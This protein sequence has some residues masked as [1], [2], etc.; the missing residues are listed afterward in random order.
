[1]I[2]ALVFSCDRAMQLDGLL[3]SI[4][5]HRV[6]YRSLTVLAHNWRHTDALAVVEAEHPD[7][8][9]VAVDGA[10]PFENEVRW[11][12]ATHDRVVFHVDDA[13]FFARPDPVVLSVESAAVSMQLGRNTV[14]CRTELGG[15]VRQKV[16]PGLVW[17][18]RDAD[19]DFGYPLSINATVY[20]TEDLLPLMDFDFGNPNQLE[21]RLHDRRERFGPE[22]MVCSPHSSCVSL[23]HNAVSPASLSP[24]GDN[25][26]WQPEALRE[27][28]MA[29]ER[30]DLG[31]MDFSRVSG[32]HQEIP[33][34]F[35][36][37]VR[38]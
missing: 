9:F 1:M 35:T 29:G 14:W 23:P 24:R 4:R 17:R 37:A 26:L 19:R 18:W 21:G 5:L 25:P 32:A 34:V 12:L 7:V 20:R 16:P 30:L 13:V 11:F 38:V 8:R 2:D 3:R 33:L 6:P 10:L 31:A 27:R 22:W 15:E 28:F 36:Q